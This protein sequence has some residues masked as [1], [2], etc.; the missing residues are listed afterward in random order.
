MGAGQFAI[1]WLERRRDF[2]IGE[3]AAIY[4]LLYIVFGTAGAFFGGA[5]S[6]RY[7]KRFS[8]GRVRFL[9]LLMVFMMPLM[10]L[11]PVM[12]VM[13]SFCFVLP[14]STLFFIGM[15][16]GMF[17]ASAFY[18]PAFSTVQ[19]L[20]L[21]RL[22]GVTTGL[23]LVACNLLGLDIE[24]VVTGYTSDILAAMDVFEPLTKAFLVV[25]FDRCRRAAK[26]YAGIRLSAQSGNAENRFNRC[27]R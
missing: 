27:I 6:D 1:V 15:A 24:A 21:V 7:Q 25:D 2:A 19:D 20:T 3:I 16:S 14:D 12:P 13:A 18:R 4:G 8:G 23:L 9:A 26:F 22:H 17:M 5:L 11:M 10:P